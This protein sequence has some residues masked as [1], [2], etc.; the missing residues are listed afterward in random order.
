MAMRVSGLNSGLDTDAIVQELV[1]AYSKKTEKYEKEQTKLSWKQEIWKS[2]NSK[3]Y[4]LYT[5]ISSLRYSSAYAIKKTTSSDTTKASVTASGSAVNGTQKLNVLQTA[6]SGYLTGGKITTTTGEKATSETKLKDLGFTEDATLRV[7]TTDKDG[8]E[9]STDVKL[10]KDSTLEEVTNE[11]AKAGLNASFDANNGRFYIS[12]KNSGTEGD[13]SIEAASTKTIPK[14]ENGEIV[15]DEYGNA[16][17]EEIETNAGEK[18]ASNR[19]LGALGLS[20]GSHLSAGAITTNQGKTANIKNTMANLGYGDGNTTF[21]AHAKVNGQEIVAGVNIGNT[22]TIEDIIEQF[23]AQG[24]NANFDGATGKLTFEGAEEISF[25]AAALRK[26]DA[27][28]NYIPDGDDWEYE[29]E[30]DGVTPK[31]DPKSQ[32]IL[33]RL[34]LTNADGTANI[35]NDTAKGAIKIDGQDAV[36]VLNGAVYTSNTNNF[37]ING[38]SITANGVTDDISNYTN[39]DENGEWDLDNID[40]TSLKGSANTITITT[41]TDTQ[42]LYDKIK[43]FLT[44]YNSIIN[45]I[46]K[47]YN[48]DSAYGYDPLTDDERDAMSDTEIEK[49]ETKIKD[50]LL[51][52]DSSLDSLM[53][54]MINSMNQAVTINGQKYSLASFGIQTLGYLNAVKNEHNALHIDGDSEDENTSGN[55]DKLMKA[56]TE[57]PDTVIEFMKQLTTNLYNAIDNNMQSS[58]LRSRYKIYNDKEMDTQYANYTKLISDWEDRVKDKED[59]YYKKF[60][61]METALSKLNSQTSSLTG[62]LGN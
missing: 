6:Q 40:L 43:D 28:G 1:S 41:S 12:S 51:R 7:K 33:K 44:Q 22:T 25:N 36:I 30:D 61:Q 3:V 20:T 16:V 37:S 19:L 17:F 11:L 5:S 49:W 59:Y 46:T 2:L 31:R 29:M 38:L 27:D 14:M 21:I 18:A 55:E 39:K 62:M 13:F 50:S 23:K 53:S 8:N 58:S 26:T 34:G 4:S 54:S 57:D 15:K 45:E 10:T 32:D 47:L 48:A 24:L 35:K 60:T 42:G 9:V 56:I 52:R